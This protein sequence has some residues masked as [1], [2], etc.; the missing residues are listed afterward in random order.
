MTTSYARRRQRRQ[1]NDNIAGFIAC[2][3]VALG[4]LVAIY[5]FSL[6]LDHYQHPRVVTLGHGECSLPVNVATLNSTLFDG[7]DRAVERCL[8]NLNGRIN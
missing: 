2:L 6:A 1:R 7:I 8:R 4:G 3:V 5:A